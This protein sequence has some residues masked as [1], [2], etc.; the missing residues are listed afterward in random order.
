MCSS[1]ITALFMWKIFSL[2]HVTSDFTLIPPVDLKVNVEA[3]WKVN[4][5]IEAIRDQQHPFVVAQTKIRFLSFYSVRH[6]YVY[7]MNINTIH[8]EAN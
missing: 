1:V 4:L 7:G 5:C 6:H 3:I 8:F 2:I